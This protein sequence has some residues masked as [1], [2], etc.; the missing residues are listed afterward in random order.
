MKI[1]NL[2]IVLLLT[3][4]VAKVFSQPLFYE[5]D[6]LQARRTLML[7]NYSVDSISNDT[8]MSSNSFRNIPTQFAVRNYF[9]NRFNNFQPVLNGVGLV[10]MSGTNVFYDNSVYLPTTGGNLTSRLNGTS[11]SLNKDSVPITTNRL[12]FL[13][14]DTSNNNRVSRQLVANVPTAANPTSLIGLTPNNGTATTYMRSDA[15]PALNLGINPIWTGTHTFSPSNPNGFV[16]DNS[17]T[18]NNNNQQGLNITGT[19]TA[20]ATANDLLRVGAIQTNLVAQANNQLMS[21]FDFVPSFTNGGFTGVQNW[22]LRTGGWFNIFNNVGL[23][24][25]TSLAWSGGVPL[26][27][28]Q[29]KP[30]ASTGGYISGTFYYGSG[31]SMFGYKFR[32]SGDD[33]ASNRLIIT[34]QGIGIMTG[35]TYHVNAST[36]IPDAAT[37]NGNINLIAAGNKIKITTGTNASCGTATLSSGTITV[38][39]TAVTSTSIILLTVQETGT[40]NGRIRVGAKVNATSFTINSSDAGDN[41]AVAWFIIN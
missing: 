7:R 34:N 13:V 24:F 12:W 26:N 6:R 11:L 22:A 1:K 25:G 41:C 9:N 21:G 36:P 33:E 29:I 28:F 38:N 20:R 35:A 2:F 10:R 27:G 14:L 39:T 4:S 17:F 8:S 37:I 32:T 31:G 30:Q 40:N 5:A 15:T 3:V 19:L 23:A 18:A 16:I